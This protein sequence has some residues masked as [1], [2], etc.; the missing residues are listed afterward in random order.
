MNANLSELVNQVRKELDEVT[1]AG[2]R[3]ETDT[4]LADTA[5][6]NF[7]D[8]SLEDR[9]LDGARFVAARVKAAHLDPFV[10]EATPSDFD[11]P[12]DGS[13]PQILRLLGSRVTAEDASGVPVACTRR[14]FARHIKM[15]NQRG[16][17]S[18][19][20]YPVFVF[21]DVELLIE[22][23]TDNAKVAHAVR[24]PGSGGN[25]HS[26]ITTMPD[27]FRGAVVQHAA[28]T[29][30][31]TLRSQDEMENARSILQRE[32]RQYR[33]PFRSGDQEDDQ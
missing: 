21:Q 32:L 22:N 29:C 33:L 18:D 27:K 3:V 26:D 14:T 28:F 12:Y 20:N 5:S 10:I 1:M 4:D 7:S 11:T 16:L 15:K 8:Q 17:T 31:Q 24:V 6:S 2:E 25:L 30:Y 9:L 13:T 23:N 19:E